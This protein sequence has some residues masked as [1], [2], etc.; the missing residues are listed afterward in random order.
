MQE[1]DNKTVDMWRLIFIA[2]KKSSRKE[3]CF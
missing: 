2:T 3:P 1:V